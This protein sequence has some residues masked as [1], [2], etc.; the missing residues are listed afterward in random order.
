MRGRPTVAALQVLGEQLMMELRRLV[1][2]E[3][4]SERP[5]VH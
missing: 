1:P 5:A 4:S 3:G 2:F